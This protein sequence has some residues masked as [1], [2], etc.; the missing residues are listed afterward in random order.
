MVTTQPQSS[1]AAGAGIGLA[2]E[3][4]D[5][6]GNQATG[7][8]GNLIAALANT[9]GLLGGPL[10]VTA[11]SGQ[12]SF[13]D[14]TIDKAGSGYTLLV[15]ASGINPVSASPFSVTAVAATQLVVTAQPTTVTAGTSY[16]LTVAA[17][18]PFGN[19]NT[20]YEGSVTVTGVSNPGVTSVAA[21]NG[22]ATF[23][24][25]ILDT[26]GA[27]SLSLTATIGQSPVEVTTN[28]I[29][30]TASAAANLVVTAQPPSS[31]TAGV[32]F[33]MVVA[34][35]DAFGNIVTNFVGN[36]TVTLP[37]TSGVLGGT[38]TEFAADGVASFTGLTLSKVNTI[39]N[40][41]YALQVTGG[42]ISATTSGITVT[43][44]AASQLVLTS[45]PPAIV[46]AGIGFGLDVEVEDAFGNQ[47]TTFNGN[48]IVALTNS[49]SLLGGPVTVK[50]N[51]GAAT[52]SGLTIDTAGTGYTLQVSGTG[53]PAVTTSP[54]SVTAAKLVLT[55][56]PPATLTAGTAFGL[57]VVVEDAFGNQA[58]YNGDVT[59][60]SASTLGGTLTV[61]AVGG[62]AS[63][64]G[65]TIDTAGTGYTLQVSTAGLP[66]LST[67]PI[68]VT[69]LIATQ[70]VVTAQPP[71]SVVAGNGFG[72]TVS[73]EDQFGNVDPTFTGN[74]TVAE[75]SG[76]AGSTLGGVTSV[77]AVGGVAVFSA[78][79]VSDV[80]ANYTLQATSTAGVATTAA[81]TATQP[82]HATQLVITAL[83]PSTVPAFQSFAL[84]ISAEDASG[85]VDSTFSG[86]VSLSL[87]NNPSG[88]I[89]GGTIIVQAVNGV[90]T[91][92][93]L[94]LNKV[95]FGYTI[96]ATTTGLTLAT[97]G[98]IS[99]TLAA[100][101]LVITS[102]PS[103]TVTAGQPFGLTVSAEDPSGDIVS[104]FTGSVTVAL[105]NNP[106]VGGL[107]GTTTVQAVNGVANF[108]GLE[109]GTA[110]IDFLNLSAG[111]YTGV[112]TTPIAIAAGAATQ[113]V[114]ISAASVTDP[115]NVTAGIGFS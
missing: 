108:T 86:N 104:T 1:Y 79:S 31:V 2:V 96:R 64:T 38:L 66:T 102:Q 97:T 62:V 8:D 57:T 17:E 115:L 77:S 89:L 112:S 98:P 85:S 99:V 87:A 25:L 26:A 3:A 43:A 45:Q 55:T 7:F 33:G 100:I 91:F 63:F 36:V 94:S 68:N 44:A 12:A 78:L 20:T 101:N 81:F 27:S 41:S 28:T 70:L 6:F 80:G 47:A 114:V 4:E 93:G 83:P 14:L 73:A 56:Q 34:T 10:T 21:N 59:V 82:I 23:T 106:D 105:P 58:D 50:A 13:S 71:S 65:L 69:A 29:T 107:V 95:G 5:A 16:S 39:A 49:P 109:I 22:V 15:S 19:V 37:H 111:S 88:G 74:V 72:L 67:S 54:F 46:A 51:G 113:L 76:P 40:P 24:G 60:A 42:L 9:P 90:A 11:V 61:T 103:G 84:S 18:D 92:A 75:M 32:G 53:L 52:F 30:V 48:L 110:G 35:E